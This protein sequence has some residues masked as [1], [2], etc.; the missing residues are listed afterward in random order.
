MVSKF[1]SEIY[2]IVEGDYLEVK[3]IQVKSKYY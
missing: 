3:N 2:N 1:G